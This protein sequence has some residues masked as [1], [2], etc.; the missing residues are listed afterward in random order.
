[1]RLNSIDF[2][3]STNTKTKE[4]NKINFLD[5]IVLLT[6]KRVEIKTTDNNFYVHYI[7]SIFA[8][9]NFLQ[10]DTTSFP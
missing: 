1:M 9:D 7:L 6:K 8:Q 4:T 5:I 2:R 3:S 10:L